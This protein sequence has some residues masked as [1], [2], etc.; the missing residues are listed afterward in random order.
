[1]PTYDDLAFCGDVH[2]V[3]ENWSPSACSGPRYNGAN[4]RRRSEGS[5]E[6]N[7]LS[8][9]VLQTQKRRRRIT[10]SAF[11]RPPGTSALRRPSHNPKMSCAVSPA[12]WGSRRK[13]PLTDMQRA[14]VA[15]NRKNKSICIRCRQNKI[16]VRCYQKLVDAT[17][18]ML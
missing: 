11:G 10:T 13:G 18:N 2:S 5:R 8:H 3:T 6:Q 17:S 4:A 12:A 9:N 7:T 16:S 14:A 1:L 15:L